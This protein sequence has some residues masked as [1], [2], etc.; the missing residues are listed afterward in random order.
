MDSVSPIRSTPTASPAP[1]IAQSEGAPA[2]A[3]RRSQ[4][5]VEVSS[6]AKAKLAVEQADKSAAQTDAAK[7][8]GQNPLKSLGV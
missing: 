7:A 6:A 5:T 2:P 8:P 1:A 4:D 3:A